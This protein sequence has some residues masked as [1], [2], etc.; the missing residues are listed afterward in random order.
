M[1]TVQPDLCCSCFS[2]LFYFGYLWKSEWTGYF[3]LRCLLHWSPSVHTNPLPVSPVHKCYTSSLI[4][5]LTL[6]IIQNFSYS[7]ISIFLCWIIVVT[8]AKLGKPFSNTLYKYNFKETRLKDGSW[9]SLSLALWPIEL[10]VESHVHRSSLQGP[11]GC[12]S[13]ASSWAWLKTC[14]QM[15]V[16][17]LF[18][19]LP[20]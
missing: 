18:Q 1:S 19:S 9:F 16:E 17:P 3:S 11:A 8:T 13:F 15:P 2:L 6:N 5:T 14:G 4:L 7:S 10:T 20:C 12:F